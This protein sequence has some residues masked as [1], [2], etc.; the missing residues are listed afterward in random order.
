MYGRVAGH[1]ERVPDEGLDAIAAELYVLPPEEFVAVR[2][3]HVKA[4][5][6]GGDRPLAAAVHDLRKPT[7]AAWL[8]NLLA[9]RD[10]DELAG[11]LALGDE[12]RAAQETL[13]G[14]ALRQLSSQRHRVVSALVTTAKRLAYE[15]GHP[16]ADDAAQEATATLEAALADPRVAE[17]VREGRLTAAVHYAGFGAPPE[18]GARPSPPARR[19]APAQKKGADDD[20]APARQRRAELAAE[21]DTAEQAAG[22]AE[23]TLAAAEE[24]LA[25]VEHERNDA[26]EQVRRLTEELEAQQERLS[27]ANRRRTEVRRERE[28]ASR[29]ATAARRRADAAR[30]RADET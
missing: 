6:S 2:E 8:V 30:A 5:R 12:L 26:E 11:L 17:V 3:A 22:E 9:H 4:L 21:A 7:Q 14:E 15:A 16:A 23:R 24:A 25:A 10:R 13:Q 1:H 27:A 20:E 19:P 28:S 18:E 29:T